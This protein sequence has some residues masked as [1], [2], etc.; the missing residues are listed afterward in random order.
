MRSGQ[1]RRGGDYSTARPGPTA[2]FGLI[3][4]I[5]VDSADD[6]R[7]GHEAPAEGVA[8]PFEVLDAA[9]GSLT[10]EVVSDR[11]FRCVAA[12]FCVRPREFAGCH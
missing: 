8:G 9:L 3:T 6:T 12:R 5:R 2:A 10:R 4:V 7:R 1:G 11:L